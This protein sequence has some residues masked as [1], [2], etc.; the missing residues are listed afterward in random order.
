MYFMMIENMKVIFYMITN[1][2]LCYELVILI[3][4]ISIEILWIFILVSKP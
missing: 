3:L 4:V 2:Y 1:I